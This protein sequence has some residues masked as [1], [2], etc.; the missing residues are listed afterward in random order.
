MSEPA[1]VL[2]LIR[3]G[4]AY[5]YSNNATVKIVDADSIWEGEDPKVKLPRGVGFE[6][7]VQEAGCEDSVEFEG[8]K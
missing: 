2:V 5:P 4:C 8:E 6:E 3:G 7:L 1:I